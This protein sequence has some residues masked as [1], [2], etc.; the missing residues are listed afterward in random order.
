MEIHTNIK[1]LFFSKAFL[2][3]K[4]RLN[5]IKKNPNPNYSFP[6]LSWQPNKTHEL[7]FK[8][9]KFKKKKG[10]TIPKEID[11]G[12]V[13]TTLALGREIIQWVRQCLRQ[14]GG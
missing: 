10:C 13:V 2:V 12:D 6:Q 8:K 14:I 7:Y 5:K 4:Q 11:G 1:F 3:P 9:K